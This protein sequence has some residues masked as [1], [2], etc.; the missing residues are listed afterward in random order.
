MK[1][2]G[3][4]LW[5]MMLALMIFCIVAVSLTRALHQ[6]IDTAV[7]LRDDSEVRRNLQNILAECSIIK[8]APGKED[9]EMGNGRIHYEREVSRIQPKNDRNQILPNLYQVTAKATWTAQNQSRSSQAELVIY[10]P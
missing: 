10:Q 6:T 8:L 5:E 9:L 4:V 1:E 3:F 7:L 2:R